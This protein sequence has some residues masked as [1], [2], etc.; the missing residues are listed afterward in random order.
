MSVTSIWSLSAW[1]RTCTRSSGPTFWRKHKRSTS[2]TTCSRPSINFTQG[3][4]CR[5]MSRY[6]SSCNPL[7]CLIVSFLMEWNSLA[8]VQ[9]VATVAG[10]VDVDMFLF[11]SYGMCPVRIEKYTCRCW[12]GFAVKSDANG[13]LEMIVKSDQGLLT[14]SSM[15]Q[16]LMCIDKVW[17]CDSATDTSSDYCSSF[18]W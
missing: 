8:L 18:Y 7:W 5:A 10:T 14:P 15:H 9:L 1:R 13:V 12:N 6:H 3:S 2:C 11:L 16:W 4:Y 17:S